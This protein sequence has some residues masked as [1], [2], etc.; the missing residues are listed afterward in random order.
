MPNE[1]W[2]TVYFE[3]AGREN[4]DETLSL[5]KERAEKLGIRNVVIASITG[6][7]GVKA[8]EVFKGFNLVV[9]TS[10]AGFEEPNVQN[11]LPGNRAIIGESG[12]KMATAAHAFGT[13]GRAVRK[14]FNTIQV[15]EIIANV[16]RLFGQGVKVAC[17][18]SCMAVDAGLL[19]TDE[20]AVAIGGTKYG[21]D[22]AIIIRPSNTHT[23][24]DARIRE[25]I[26]KPRL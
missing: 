4:T 13:L 14:K 23:F 1:V 9:V 22:T 18:V 16:L 12:A 25:I 10:V 26:C 20:D 24:F 3:K 5:A 11:F 21:S 2:K 8:S 19:R 7:T 6:A 17:E 15:D